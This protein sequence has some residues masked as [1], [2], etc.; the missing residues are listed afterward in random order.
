MLSGGIL[1]LVADAALDS[2]SGFVVVGFC[3][4]TPVAWSKSAGKQ[5]RNSPESVAAAF[6]QSPKAVR[7]RRWYNMQVGVYSYRIDIG[8]SMCTIPFVF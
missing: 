7:L 1:V 5:F 4:R 3:I 6:S 8:S 2:A